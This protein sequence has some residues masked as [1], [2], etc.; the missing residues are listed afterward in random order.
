MTAH[1][2]A[3]E[4]MQKI[5]NGELVTCKDLANIRGCLMFSTMCLDGLDPERFSVGKVVAMIDHALES[6]VVTV[7]LPAVSAA[8]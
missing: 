5:A 2:K 8:A 3:T 6:A 7:T 4:D 1:Q